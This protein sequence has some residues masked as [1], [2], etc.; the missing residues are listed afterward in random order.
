MKG[1]SQKFISGLHKNGVIAEE[2]QG[3]Y[4][5]AL[6]ILVTGVLHFL[7]SL[8]IG[9]FIGAVKES[10]ALFISFFIIRKFAG[11]FH[12]SSP[13]KCYLFSIVMSCSMLLLVKHLA[14]STD[15]WIYYSIL[16]VAA[17]VVII[18]SPIEAKNKPFNDKERK[19][20]KTVSVVL[21]IV[22]SA[23]S[24]LIFTFA[25]K[26]IGIAIS[27]G[28]VTETVV[29][30]F[31]VIQIQIKKTTKNKKVEALSNKASE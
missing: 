31:A 29:L 6:N 10:L 15:N 19:V 21:S 23:I 1:L 9:I 27:F 12:T 28:M 7:I 2:D 26:S 24:I 8:L 4:E 11:G 17:M 18:F 22:I 25:S 5:Y 30:I 3:L 16:A 13:V 14:Q 20:F